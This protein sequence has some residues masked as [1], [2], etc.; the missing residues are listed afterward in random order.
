MKGIVR[1]VF[2][3]ISK[4]TE[5]DLND[6]KILPTGYALKKGKDGRFQT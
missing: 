2:A 1:N 3:D 4:R 5:S 6:L